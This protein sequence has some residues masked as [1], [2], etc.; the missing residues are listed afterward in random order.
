MY[1]S[2]TFSKVLILLSTKNQGKLLVH[3]LITLDLLIESVKALCSLANSNKYNNKSLI[4]VSKSP[5][6]GI[7][8]YFMYEN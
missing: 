3:L 1:L 7:L 6:L 8:T 4:L 5:I 2:I